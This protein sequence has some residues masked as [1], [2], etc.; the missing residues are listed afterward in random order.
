MGEFHFLARVVM[1][2]EPGPPMFGVPSPMLIQ[3]PPIEMHGTPSQPMRSRPFTR[4]SH[5]VVVEQ[6]DLR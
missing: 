1:R 6:P 2:M 3:R 5:S 4:R